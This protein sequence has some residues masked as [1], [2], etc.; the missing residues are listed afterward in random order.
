MPSR[1]NVM[2]RWDAVQQRDSRRALGRAIKRQDAV[3]ASDRSE[4]I[5]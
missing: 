2:L 4:L 1:S 5:G 3:E